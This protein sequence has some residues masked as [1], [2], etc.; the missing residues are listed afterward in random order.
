MYIYAY[1]TQQLLLVCGLITLNPLLL[2]G[3]TA[4]ATVPLA[5]ASWFL[6]EKPA[7]RL[8]SRFRRNLPAPQDQDQSQGQPAM[9]RPT[10]EAEP[11][12]PPERPGTA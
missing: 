10:H 3:V 7:R 2:T 11:A 6:I 5:A 1:P 4:A 12:L 8:K 9:A